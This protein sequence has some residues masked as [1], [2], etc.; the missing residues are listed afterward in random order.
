MSCLVRQGLAQKL[1]NDFFSILGLM[2]QPRIGQQVYT[3]LEHIK[4]VQTLLQDIL[5]IG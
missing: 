5:A 3:C 2:K 4:E 1:R